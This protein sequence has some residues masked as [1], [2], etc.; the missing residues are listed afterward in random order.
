MSAVSL[1]RPLPYIRRLIRPQTRTSYSN[2][3]SE[4][5]SYPLDFESLEGRIDR[6]L[7]FRSLMFSLAVILWRRYVST[8]ISDTDPKECFS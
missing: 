1:D 6:T 7:A 3:L 2:V 5:L 4:S 8:G